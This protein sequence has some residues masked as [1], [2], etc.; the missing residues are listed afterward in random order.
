MISQRVIRAKADHL[1]RLWE[2][3]KR[4]HQ[5]EKRRAQAAVKERDNM[6]QQLQAT[7]VVLTELRGYRSQYQ[8]MQTGYTKLKRE[9]DVATR[10]VLID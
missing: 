2:E 3:E 6:T 5:L 10:K 9:R 4:G 1:V 8:I 7:K